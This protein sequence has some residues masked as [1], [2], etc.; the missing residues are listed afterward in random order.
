MMFEQSALDYGQLR[1]SK[2]LPQ[3]DDAYNG[4]LGNHQCPVGV[5]KLSG[6]E[7]LMFSSP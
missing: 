2:R 6:A 3:P 4:Q 5:L 7:F 1:S